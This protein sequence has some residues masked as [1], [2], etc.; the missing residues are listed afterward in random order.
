MDTVVNINVTRRLTMLHD[1]LVIVGYFRPMTI[2]YCIWCGDIQSGEM[3][4]SALE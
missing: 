4:Q 3:L 2:N 1:L